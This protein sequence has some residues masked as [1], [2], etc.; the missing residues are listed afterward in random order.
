M[1]ITHDSELKDGLYK[2][3]S[4]SKDHNINRLKQVKRLLKEEFNTCVKAAL[5]GASTP[6]AV[7]SNQCISN[8]QGESPAAFL[9][10][11]RLG[12]GPSRQARL[13]LYINPSYKIHPYAMI[14]PMFEG[15]LS[16]PGVQHIVD[17]AN[18][19]YFT[20]SLIKGDKLVEYTK[21]VRGFEAQVIQHEC[22][23]LNGKTIW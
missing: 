10:Q 21:L 13:E 7:A 15:C 20:Y 6:I 11:S 3:C 9:Y 22:D 12:Q 5:P 4:F 23:H 14:V 2:P 19:V 17:R 16:D 1:I 18:L 8:M